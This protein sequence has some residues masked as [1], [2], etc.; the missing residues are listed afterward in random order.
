MRTY[1]LPAIIALIAECMTI[2]AGAYSQD[3][4]KIVDQYIKAEGGSKILSKVNTFKARR[5]LGQHRK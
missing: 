1:L 2:P 3:V 5:Y 4:A